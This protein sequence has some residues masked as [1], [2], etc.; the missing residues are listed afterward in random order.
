ME[1]MFVWVNQICPGQLSSAEV[2]GYRTM[3]ACAIK[4]SCPQEAVAASR[5][6]KKVATA[7]C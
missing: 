4:P 7:H 1:A 3:Y 5:E 2:D 6:P